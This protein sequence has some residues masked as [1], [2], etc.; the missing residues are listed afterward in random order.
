MTEVSPSI[1]VAVCTF[2]RNE[3]LRQ[4]LQSIVR[5][6][7]HLEAEARIGVIVVDD[8]PDE[9]ARAVCM[10]FSG[11]FPLGL[12]YRTSGK[13]NISIGRNIALETALGEGAEWIAMTDD[14]CLP[15]D[16]WLSSY[17]QTQKTT[18]CDALTGP[19]ILVPPDGA[20]PWLTEQ[21]FLEDAQFRFADRAPM[22]TAATNNSFFN[23]AFFRDR[24]ELRFVPDLG[25]TG[26]EDMVFFRTASQAGLKICFSANSIVRGIEPPERATF[27][28]QLSS[29]FWL[30]N[31]EYVTNR[32][33][34][35]A[36]AAW[37]FVR[38]LKVIATAGARP[39]ARLARG[40]SPQLRYAVAGMAR[41]LGM[42]CGA[43]GLQLRHH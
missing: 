43:G 24:P 18:G 4:L 14:D 36:R 5:N 13:G 29:H 23:A 6:Q 26:G 12:H 2:R 15:T 16:E 32:Y 19:C 17:L 30:G 21:P 28:Y 40:R 3:P 11:S 8:N 38:G 41:G 27:K 37:W 34:G 35:E 39:V 31:T 9:A 33:M 22:N 20:P 1:F 42:L 7:L 10:D 25:V